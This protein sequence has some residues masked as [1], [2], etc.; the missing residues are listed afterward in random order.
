MN[1]SREFQDVESICSGKLSHVPSQPPVVPSLSGMLSRDQS[2][3]PEECFSLGNQSVTGANPV[4]ESTG[5]LVA[6]SEE[7]NRET[8]PTPRFLNR[9]SNMN[10]FFP[11]ELSYPQKYVADQSI[12]QISELQFDTFSTPSTFSCWKIRCK[13]QVSACFSSLLE[14]M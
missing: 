8:S 5:Q 9:P 14:G 4:R 6:R 13:T 7:R 12:P 1:D 3:R 11:A 2:L 10:S